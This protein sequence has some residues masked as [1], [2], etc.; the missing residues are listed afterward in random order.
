MRNVPRKAAAV[1]IMRAK[2]TDV[3]KAALGKRGIYRRPG[4]TLAHDKA[5]APVPFGPCGIVFKNIRIKHGNNV[6]NGHHRRNVAAARQ[7]RHFNTVPAYKPCKLDAGH[8]ILLHLRTPR[9]RS[10]NPQCRNFNFR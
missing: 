7:M 10:Q 9:T 4:V 8:R 2:L 1:G 5:V 3:K 6:R